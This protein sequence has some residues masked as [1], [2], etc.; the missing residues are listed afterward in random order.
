MLD[1]VVAFSGQA[2]GQHLDAYAWHC[3]ASQRWLPYR[4]FRSEQLASR[5]ARYGRFMA[6][7]WFLRWHRTWKERG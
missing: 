2:D 6:K 5:S 3:N 1:T 7:I 4:P